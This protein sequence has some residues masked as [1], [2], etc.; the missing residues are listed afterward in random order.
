M[1]IRCSCT[2]ATSRVNGLVIATPGKQPVF[3]APYLTNAIGY[4]PGKEPAPVCPTNL[5][6]KL[7]GSIWTAQLSVDDQGHAFPASSPGRDLERPHAGRAG[8]VAPSEGA[9]ARS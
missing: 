8:A 7:T 2:T 6:V 1:M 4:L 5:E 3:C 9:A